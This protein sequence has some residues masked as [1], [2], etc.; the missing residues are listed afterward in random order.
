MFFSCFFLLIFS[1]DFI[2]KLLH[3]IQQLKFKRQLFFGVCFWGRLVHL[4]AAEKDKIICQKLPTAKLSCLAG[5]RKI[6]LSSHF[7]GGH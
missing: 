1:L 2:R 5:A 6:L 3:I 7:I 4:P